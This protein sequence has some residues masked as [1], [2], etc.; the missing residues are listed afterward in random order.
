MIPKISQA[1]ESLFMS[2]SHVK[3]CDQKNTIDR[4]C[5]RPLY[6][7]EKALDR[8]LLYEAGWGKKLTYIIACSKD[9][10]NDVTWRYSADHQALILRR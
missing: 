1:T 9:D 2:D 10:I 6:V 8:P 7:G 3:L 4:S 5:Y